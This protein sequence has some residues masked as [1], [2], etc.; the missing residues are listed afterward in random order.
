MRAKLILIIGLIVVAMSVGRVAADEQSERAELETVL[1]TFLAGTAQKSVHDRFWAKDLVYTSS[2]GARYGKDT[3]LA[4]FD[5]QSNAERMGLDYG[6]ED[7]NIR[8]RGDI[9]VITF[10]L[11]ADSEGKR[12][13]E[14]MN[15]GVFQ[16]ESDS[17][18]AF[19][20]HATRI[21]DP[22]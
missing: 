7:I 20:W 1:R 13:S 4:G 14:Y 19:T 12:V 8:F 3:I 15:T 2:S 9:A 6:A 17:W 22:S 11:T 21:P 5:D 10:R 16:R 18:R